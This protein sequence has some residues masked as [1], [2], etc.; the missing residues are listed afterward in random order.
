MPLSPMEA[1]LAAIWS[2]LLDLPSGSRVG[3]AD[4][5]FALGGHSLLATQVVARVRERFGVELP[6][7]ALF[8]E[9]T[10]SGLAARV[11]VAQLALGVDLTAAVP[12]ASLP[13]LRR[14]P[15]APGAARPASFAQQRLWFLDRLEPGSALY[16][17][18]AALAVRGALDVP[19]LARVLT[20]IGRR[21]ETLRT[22]FVEEG[23][24]PRQ[25]VRPPAPVAVPLVDLAALPAARRFAEARALADAE[26]GR[27][28]DLARGPLWRTVLLRLLPREHEALV[29]VHHIVSDGWSTEVLVREVAALYTAFTA[30]RPSP[31]PAGSAGN[32]GSAGL[33]E[34]PV[35]YA[36]YAVWQR[37][38]LSGPVLAGEVAW[39]RRQLAGAAPLDLPFDRPRP[40]SSSHRGEQ[41]DRA[42]APALAA[43]LRAL[44]RRY[45]ATLFMTLTAAFQALLAR[46][47]GQDDVSVGTPVAGRS[48]VEIEGLIGFFVNTLV[49][50]QDLAGDPPFRELLGRVRET[51]LAAQAHQAV[52]FERL[53]EELAPE[54]SLSLSPLFQVLFA[55]EAAPRAAL[56][57]PGLSLA[58]L[59]FGRPA[60]GVAKFD[61]TWTV[62]EG[63]SGLGSSLEFSTDLF[64]RATIARWASHL[65]RLL[66]AVVDDPALPLSRLP[67]LSAAERQQAIAL[68]A[69]AE[70]S[71]DEHGATL[72]ELFLAQASRTPDALAVEG[73]TEALT[74]AELRRRAERLARRLQS[75]GVGPETIVG[76]GLERTPALV[77]GLLGAL[78]AG[79]V[80]LPLDPALPEL[81]RNLLLADSGARVLVAEAR[82]LAG[83]ELPPDVQRLA[84]D[85]DETADPE[86]PRA[87]GTRPESLAYVIY[88]SGSTG[89]PKGVGVEHGAAAAH[90]LGAVAAFGLRADDRLL[91]FVSPG[92]DMSLDELLP[93]LLC[94]A[95]IV[96]GPPELPHPADL[97][98][99]LARRRI[100][101]LHPPTAYWQQWVREA[102]R[103]GERAARPPLGV[104]ITGGEAMSPASLAAWR[105]LR[106]RAA[107]EARLLNGYGPT[108][109]I[110]TATLYE[111]GDA[112]AADGG[113]VSIGRPLPGRTAHVLDRY[114]NPQ[115]AGVPGELLLGGLLAR[116]YLGDPQRTAERFVPDP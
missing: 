52:P 13:P 27:P 88:T 35:Q 10:L 97:L 77:V 93:T 32:G 73:L 18:P 65:E 24:E 44:G 104:V 100:S 3:A 103:Q 70:I 33:P 42:L 90:F 78:A 82:R 5:F 43:G 62:A 12:S 89:R 105:E 38:L 96:F 63:A 110:V 69:G 34:L 94:G 74:Y 84:L 49:L 113:A 98:G 29:T 50:R 101:V 81:R 36:D 72:W 87:A 8:E 47:S 57:L 59:P 116:G 86:P 64:D 76:V 7:R 66:A 39:W 71:T 40:A 55:L 11:E 1:A 112:T 45:G 22:V 6:V 28:F 19:A 102:P 25:L 4:G 15:A 37:A 9:P 26:A 16:N 31:R 46:L 41:L 75:S 14:S 20:E 17:I 85:A 108:E 30:G 61:L 109:T 95:A 83:W 2:E 23:G 111:V 53:V 115:P 58:P 91:Q 107:P 54:R 21:H 48:H 67:L 106:D 99:E 60:G 114:G 56:D 51:S 80:Y 79:G 68:A 92:F